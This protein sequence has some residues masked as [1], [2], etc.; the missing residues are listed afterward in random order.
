[1]SKIIWFALA[2][3]VL[4]GFLGVMPIDE[5]ERHHILYGFLCSGLFL[6]TLFLG[7]ADFK[8]I[9]D[10]T[11]AKVDG[12]IPNTR[13]LAP[14]AIIPGIALFFFLI[15]YHSSR[16]DTELEKF[17]VMTK[18][19]VTGG[20][21]RT[22]SR[23]GRKSTSYDVNFT[24]TDSANH[25]YSVEDNVSGD[26]FDKLYEGAVID[27][28]YSRRYPALAEAVLNL[29]DLQ[30]YKKIAVADVAIE[31]LIPLLESTV[32]D[33]SIITYLNTVCY[34]W[35]V[36]S[37]NQTYFINDHKDVAIQVGKDRRRVV[38]I[39]ETTAYAYEPEHPFEKS[40]ETYGFK[41]K[42]S[43]TDGKT[44]DMFYT[45][46]YTITKERQIPE[47]KDNTDFLNQPAFDIWYVEKVEQ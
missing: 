24:Y 17:G 34:E 23:R 37:D 32:K 35:R 41:K 39:K 46:K 1:M 40:L 14:I 28:V 13:K 20:E 33:D 15:F 27:I 26:E 43:T 2:A 36:D 45:D 8:S 25:S 18:G 9:K 3:F 47:S 42:S 6:V 22:S 21:S 44:N 11:S 12:P 10:A 16:I 29:K 31:H 30:K 5:Y 4:I 38:Y 19:T 7:L